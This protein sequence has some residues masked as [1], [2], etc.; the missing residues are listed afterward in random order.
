MRVD[1]LVHMFS[2]DRTP[3]TSNQINISTH[4]C[5]E[6]QVI[7]ELILDI[8]RF[9]DDKRKQYVMYYC[10]ERNYHTDNDHLV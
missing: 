10:T 1:N 7:T 9:L 3:R 2:P 8:Y 5:V 6:T 4:K